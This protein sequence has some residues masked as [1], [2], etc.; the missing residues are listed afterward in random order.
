[1]KNNQ[2]RAFVDILTAGFPRQ[3]KEPAEVTR[4]DLERI[5]AAKQKRARKAW[6]KFA[7]QAPTGAASAIR[8]S[9]NVVSLTKI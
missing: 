9:F 7:T 5:E 6:A 1:M 8:S 3:K 2:R 4:F